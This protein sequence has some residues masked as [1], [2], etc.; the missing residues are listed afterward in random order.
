MS[1]IVVPIESA[2]ENLDRTHAEFHKSQFVDRRRSLLA[3]LRCLA[4]LPEIVR[5]LNPGTTYRVVYPDGVVLQKGVDGL[6]RA[7]IRDETGKIVTHAKLAEVGPNL[8]NIA[9]TLAGQALLMSIVIQLTSIEEKI[10]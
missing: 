3:G 8:L 9:A 5:S 1:N 10:D 6:S 2:C 4:G 7:V